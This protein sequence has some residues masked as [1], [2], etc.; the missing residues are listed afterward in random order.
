MLWAMNPWAGKIWA[1]IL[2]EAMNR[3]DDDGPLCF[4]SLLDRASN[5]EVVRPPNR[6]RQLAVAVMDVVPGLRR[7][8]RN[9]LRGYDFLFQIDLAFH[10]LP[11][12]SEEF[13][14]PHV[15]G[16]VWVKSQPSRRSRTGLSPGVWGCRWRRC[17]AD[18]RTPGWASRGVGICSQGRP[19][20]GGVT[21]PDYRPGRRRQWKG[22]FCLTWQHVAALLTELDG[23]TKPSLA[24]GF[25][26]CRG[27][28]ACP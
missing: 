10:R 24:L 7:K 18:R 25:G 17:T 13:L 2:A 1:R 20:R 9:K 28:P 5:I 14:C 3:L 16:V 4:V 19:N 23:V 8:F 27:P 21:F 26:G 12:H 15:H 22:S 11:R 6:P